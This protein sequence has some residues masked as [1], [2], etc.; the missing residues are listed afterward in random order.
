MTVRVMYRW[1]ND[2]PISLAICIPGIVGNMMS[3]FTWKNIRDKVRLRNR[4]SVQF[5][6]ALCIVDIMVLIFQ[7][8]AE[9]LPNMITSLKNNSLFVTFYIYIGHPSHFYFLFCTILLVAAL[10]I[11]RT[12]FVI[13]PF[14]R[15]K[16]LKSSV[17]YVLV[18]V[19][20]MAGLLNI[21]S[22]FEYRSEERNGT[23]CLV[24]VSYA[25][26]PI[27]RDVVFYT[28]CLLG[29]AM[30]WFAIFMCNI[31]ITLFTRIKLT[32]SPSSSVSSNWSK[33]STTLTLVSFSTLILLAFQCISRCF[34]MFVLHPHPDYK[35]HE[36]VANYGNLAIPLNSAL[37][38]IMF[39]LPGKQFRQELKKILTCAKR[40]RSSE[41]Q[42]NLQI[43]SGIC[44][45]NVCYKD[46]SGSCE[47]QRNKDSSGL[48]DS[49]RNNITVV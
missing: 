1:L 38:I 24:K 36:K 3:I 12:L 39:S 41:S 47:S 44:M 8:V 14:R 40:E 30:P 22:F 13:K 35:Y 33:M 18:A 25:N 21:P 45:G 19:F 49:Q 9:V 43:A 34:T 6:I 7:L 28:H 42:T 48:H 2:V 17:A 5:F 11:D 37:N 26:D 23:T 46:S 32:K 4:R 27:V 20:V 16:G 15:F 31:I 29:I 10:S